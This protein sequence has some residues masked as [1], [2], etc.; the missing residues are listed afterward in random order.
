M[1]KSNLKKFNILNCCCEKHVSLVTRKFWKERKNNS[2]P[3]GYKA[4]AKKSEKHTYLQELIPPSHMMNCT[5]MVMLTL[6]LLLPIT[7][8]HPSEA[9]AVRTHA[10]QK[11]AFPRSKEELEELKKNIEDRLAK[12]QPGPC[13]VEGVGCRDTLR[14]LAF[15]GLTPSRLASALRTQPVKKSCAFSLGNHCLT[16]SMDNA[17][18]EYGYLQSGNSPGRR[19]RRR[20]AHGD[21]LPLPL[22]PRP[23]LMQE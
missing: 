20:G 14:S 4:Q 23:L 17:A 16:E 18:T 19:R 6:T 8:P 5:P 21:T 9:S 2:I 7:A 10:R 15:L 1:L 3:P 11:R 13:S 12:L 22:R